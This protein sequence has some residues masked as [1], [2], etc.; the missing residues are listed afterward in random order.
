MSKTPSFWLQ[1]AL[2]CEELAPLAAPIL[3]MTA[4]TAHALDR[5]EARAH[6]LSLPS[7]EVVKPPVKRKRTT[8]TTKTT[9]RITPTK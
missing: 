5:A 1:F 8:K 2:A 7:A 9:K 4:Q 3:A 6:Q